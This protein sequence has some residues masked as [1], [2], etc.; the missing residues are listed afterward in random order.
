MWRSYSLH[1][2]NFLRADDAIGMTDEL[3]NRRLSLVA[4]DAFVARGIDL[5]RHDER[6]RQALKSVAQG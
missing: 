5:G 6:R 3:G 1:A 4:I 2:D